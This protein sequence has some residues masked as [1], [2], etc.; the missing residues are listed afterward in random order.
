MPTAIARLIY[1]NL[2]IIILGSNSNDNLHHLT[3]FI[4]QTINAN[5]SK[6]RNHCTASQTVEVQCVPS[7][8][9]DACNMHKQL[10]MELDKHSTNHLLL[11]PI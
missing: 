6:M 9:I 7:H 8:N 10:F 5:E 1:D 3:Q 2:W 11:P 4:S